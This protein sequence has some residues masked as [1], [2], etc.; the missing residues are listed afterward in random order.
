MKEELEIAQPNAAQEAAKDIAKYLDAF[1]PLTLGQR[2]VDRLAAI[3]SKHCCGGGE[4]DKPM[5]EVKRLRE[6]L[7]SYRKIVRRWQHHAFVTSRLLGC[8]SIDEEIETAIDKLKHDYATARAD[9]I[10]E[11]VGAIKSLFRKEGDPSEHRDY[12]NGVED[13]WT[14]LEQLKG[15]GGRDVTE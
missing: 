11:C 5:G 13:S 4:A 2:E 3:I 12:N 1:T 15:E 6:A 10:G 8:D 9:A 7:R 14:A